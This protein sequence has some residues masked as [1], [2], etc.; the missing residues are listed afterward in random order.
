MLIVD[1]Y[2]EVE[3]GLLKFAVII[4]KSQGKWVFCKHKDRTTYECPGGHREDSEDILDTAKR[5][6]FEET[7]A[8]KY[9]L[10]KLGA[11]SVCS[12]D[13]LEEKSKKSYGMLYYA[14]IT[15]F[16]SLPDYEI[17]KVVLSEELP[18]CWTYPD[19]QPKLLEK[20]SAMISQRSGEGVRS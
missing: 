15:E 16:T 11:Y 2:D 7:G 17:E 1:F 4:A 9:R 6:L 10:T 13:S 5:E 14:D 8:T 19:I 20:V 18:D 12:D 3:D